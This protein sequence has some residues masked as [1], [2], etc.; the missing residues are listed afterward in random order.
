MNFIAPS[1]VTKN[2]EAVNSQT[3]KSNCFRPIGFIEERI[4]GNNNNGNFILIS[5]K[6]YWKSDVYIRPKIC[7]RNIETIITATLLCKKAVKRVFIIFQ[8]PAKET[9]TR[10]NNLLKNGFS[11]NILFM[12]RMSSPSSIQSASR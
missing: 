10:E 6:A 2:R 1:I 8:I 7:R 4:I 11:G 3:T 12:E 9:M 5:L